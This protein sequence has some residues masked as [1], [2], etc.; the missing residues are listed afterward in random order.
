MSPYDKAYQ[1]FQSRQAEIAVPAWDDVHKAAFEAGM[2]FGIDFVMS[3]VGSVLEE[4]SQSDA[5]GEVGK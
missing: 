1:S 3:Q 5:S 2:K 4:R